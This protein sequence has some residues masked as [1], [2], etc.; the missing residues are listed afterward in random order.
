M[1]ENELEAIIGRFAPG[2]FAPGH[3][4]AQGVRSYI[5]ILTAEV[6]RVTRERDELLP[7]AG[8]IARMR[9]HYGRGFEEGKVQGRALERE[10]CAKVADEVDREVGTPHVPFE[11]GMKA[12]AQTIAGT[13]RARGES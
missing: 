11:G 12:A 7:G 9:E 8:E 5:E 3:Y 1:T 6:R 13:I 4:E 10:A 2:P